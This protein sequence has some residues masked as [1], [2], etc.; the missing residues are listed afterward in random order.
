VPV[1]FVKFDPAKTAEDGSA[2]DQQ[3]N[4]FHVMGVEFSDG[5]RG[6]TQYASPT[7][8]DVVQLFV[9][10]DGLTIANRLKLIPALLVMLPQESFATTVYH[11]PHSRRVPFAT[12]ALDGGGTRLVPYPVNADPGKEDVFVAVPAT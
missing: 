7:T 2:F 3:P 10:I 1:P 5:G 4:E 6:V 12:V 9:L 8:R 11:P